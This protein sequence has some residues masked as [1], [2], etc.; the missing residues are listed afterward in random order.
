MSVGWILYHQEQY[1][2]NKEYCDLYFQAFKKRGIRI[3]LVVLESLEINIQNNQ[4]VFIHGG[5]VSEEPDFV[6]N[7]TNNFLIA[8]LL[9]I[10][11]IKVFN[12]SMVSRLCNDKRLTYALMSKL[13][14]PT[15]D[16]YLYPCSGQPK[17]Y[18]LVAKDSFGSGGKQVFLVNNKAEEIDCLKNKNLLLQKKCE[19]V[20]KDVRV[21]VIGKSI[22][23]AILRESTGDFRSNYSLGGSCKVVNLDEALKTAVNRIIDHF[24][25]GMV[26][27]DFLYSEG[28]YYFNEIEDSVGAR[29]VYKLTDIDIVDLYVEFIVA[30]L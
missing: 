5:L 2:K 12:N 11:G 6:I 16:T 7:R 18:P 8:E 26:G 28:K 30:N 27:I 29:M 13:G 20:G 25:F 17:Y 3:E 14:I 15:M 10:H 1:D 19:E 9:E 23:C 4:L 21:Y 24:D 22:V